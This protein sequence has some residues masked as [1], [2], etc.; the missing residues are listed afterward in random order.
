MFL[1]VNK[2]TKQK[3]NA[4]VAQLAEATASKAVKYRFESDQEHSMNYPSC[5]VEL[6][7][8]TV[9]ELTFGELTVG[10]RRVITVA[11]TINGTNW[12]LSSDYTL[13]G[14]IENA[15]YLIGSGPIFHRG[16]RLSPIKTF[17][18]TNR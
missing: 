8:G 2:N 15:L 1:G 6:L 3:H 9:L 5:N 4:P 16:S 12:P 17:T 14:A 18:R 13:D 10:D 11:T 7:D